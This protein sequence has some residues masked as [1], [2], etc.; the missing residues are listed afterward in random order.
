MRQNEGQTETEELTNWRV[1]LLMKSFKGHDGRLRCPGFREKEPDLLFSKAS[2]LFKSK[3]L[4][5]SGTSAIA[6]RVKS[7]LLPLLFP[8][9]FG[10]AP[11]EQSELD[12]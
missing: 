3:F 6:A 5:L 7:T 2:D 11:Y 9:R 8:M 12:N 1:G 4:A 10:C